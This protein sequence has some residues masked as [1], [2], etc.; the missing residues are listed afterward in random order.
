MINR[1][2]FMARRHWLRSVTR[3]VSL[4]GI[5]LLAWSLLARGG[6]AC[7]RLTLPCQECELLAHCRLPRARRAKGP[8]KNTK[9]TP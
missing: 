7:F 2:K 9:A 8:L 4:G 1:D 5:G 3:Y 6:G